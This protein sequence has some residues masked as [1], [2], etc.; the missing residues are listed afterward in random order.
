[1]IIDDP[2]KSRA[3]AESQVYRD[4]AW[5]WWESTAVSRLSERSRVL[6]IMTRWHE[7]DL[8]GRI[9]RTEG[10]DWTVVRIPAIAEDAADPLGRQVGEELESVQARRPGWFVSLSGRLSRY[11]WT[12]LYQQRPTAAEGN[13]IR[14]ADFRYW[15][16]LAN[17]PERHDRLSGAR[18]E[19]A[20]RAVYLADCFRFAT[21]DLAGTT[22][23]RSD[24]TVGAAWAITPDGDLLL[25][26][27][28]R[29]RIE[30]G[31]H[32][33][34]LSPM[35]ARWE[36]ETTYVERGM[37]GTTLIVEATRAGVRIEPL[38]PDKDKTTRAIPAA[39]RIAEH[40][41]MFPAGREWLDEWCDELAA[42]PS[43]THDDQVDVLAYAVRVAATHWLP[44]QLPPRSTRGADPDGDAIDRAYA[45]ATGLGIHADLSALEF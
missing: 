16:H 18:A 19:V 29:L 7:D 43:G 22:R 31:D 5:D 38:D 44:E 37:I 26:D 14:R 28:V 27:R 34:H 20:G 42:F 23:T 40:R 9:L 13:L 4:A 45:A 1:M 6:L 12:S 25:L 8:A 17:D 35:I 30:E 41:V 24:W 36:L 3:E 15:T 2:V 33:A 21:V 39:N 11:V 32:F 10:E